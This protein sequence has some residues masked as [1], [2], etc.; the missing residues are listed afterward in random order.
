MQNELLIFTIL[1]ALSRFSSTI[2]CTTEEEREPRGSILSILVPLYHSLDCY[3]CNSIQNAACSGKD[4]S[5]FRQTCD[6]STV[7]PYCRRISQTVDGEKSIV[8]DCG[9][10][11]GSAPC[12]STT[13]GNSVSISL[14]LS[15]SSTSVCSGRSLLM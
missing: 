3:V 11:Q 9:S 4:L 14:L 5:Q 6:N 12:Y 10:K 2:N 1:F 8:R 7:D 13:G 15:S